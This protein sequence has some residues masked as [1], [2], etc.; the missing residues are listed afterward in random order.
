M[1]TALDLIT[2]AMRI[3]K[4]YGTGETVSD[5][6]ATDGLASLNAMLEDWANETLMIYVA[7]KDAIVLTP[8]LASYTVG[9]SGSTVSARP[10]SIDP[11]TYIDIGGV[12]Y[13]LDVATLDQYNSITIKTLGS[14]IPRYI[15]YSPTFPNATVTLYPVPAEAGTLNLWTWKPLATFDNLTDV[16]S[17]PPGYTNAIVYNLAEY[18]APEYGSEI[19]ISVHGKAMTLKKKLKRT[20]FTPMFLQFPDE[21]P[22]GFNIY[23]G[24]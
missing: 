18:L 4:V 5:A 7:T 14:S 15:F 24:E 22:R 9:P 6:E 12:S 10:V 20:N 17:L 13:P 3:I 2:R 21:V 1:A 23:T 11:G 8:T 16:V 19:H